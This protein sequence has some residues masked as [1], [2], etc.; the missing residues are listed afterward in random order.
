MFLSTHSAISLPACGSI[1]VVT[2]VARFSRALPSS[3]SSSCTS[4]YATSAGTGSSASR[5]RGGL[6][7]A[8]SAGF[9]IPMK[10]FASDVREVSLELGEPE[11]RAIG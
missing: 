6:T 10:G 2:N 8:D 4:W 1:H 3:S 7:S 5:V 11:C 9:A